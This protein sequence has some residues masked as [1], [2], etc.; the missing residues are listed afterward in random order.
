MRDYPDVY[1]GE[2]LLLCAADVNIFIERLLRT[3]ASY[4]VNPYALNPQHELTLYRVFPVP[5]PLRVYRRD[6]PVIV[7][8]NEVG[9]VLAWSLNDL[10]L[11]VTLRWD[12]LKIHLPI[13]LLNL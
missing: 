13:K 10:I 2:G 8:N 3:G 5:H 4:L 7:I 9:L 6:F 12:K 11:A 1:S